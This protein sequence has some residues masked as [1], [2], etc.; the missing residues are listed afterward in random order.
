MIRFLALPLAAMMLVCLD[1]L[2]DRGA[3]SAPAPSYVGSEACGSCHSEQTKAWADSHH[4]WALRPPTPENI[5][6]DFDNA[7]F[8]HNGQTSRFSRKDGRFFVETDGEDG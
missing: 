8:V 4:S 7:S 5:L 1:F 6:G 3:L 2:L